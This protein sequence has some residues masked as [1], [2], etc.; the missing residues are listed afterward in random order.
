MAEAAR[1]VLV[2]EDLPDTR[3]WLA[4][5]VVQ[6]LRSVD[7]TTVPDLRSAR[8]WLRDLDPAAQPPLALV[9]LGLPDGSGIDFIRELLAREPRSTVVVATI[10]ADDLHL[11]EAMAVGAE[12]Y[13]LKDQDAGQLV[14]RLQ[15]LERGE[16]AISPQIARRILEHF[17]VT[18]RFQTADNGQAEPLTPREVEVLRLIG[19]GLTVNEAADVLG[20]SRQTL[21]GYVKTIYRKLGISTRAEAAM[22]ALRRNLV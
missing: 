22:E 3:A 9:D 5:V 4:E 11:M 12:G 16:A 7:L 17:R 1:P 13:L 15:A 14:E 18:A 2:L 19:R 8:L 21:P 6:A 20:V 10:Y